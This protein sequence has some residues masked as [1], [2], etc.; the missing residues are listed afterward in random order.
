MTP[1]PQSTEISVTAMTGST[2]LPLGGSHNA[3]YG[4]KITPV[5]IT[6]DR[7]VI[8]EGI[9]KR[10]ISASDS[11]PRIKN[12]PLRAAA[13]VKGRQRLAKVAEHLNPGF[14]PLSALRLASGLSQAELAEKMNMKQPNI[15]RLE[16]SPGDP[17]LSTLRKLAGVLGVEVGQV[18]AA[19]EATNKA[20]ADRV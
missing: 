9:A 1:Q 4:L 19:V 17:S 12:N 13:I 15:A 7:H 6:M 18:I 20:E 5:F 3:I 10:G 14:R 8:A 16:K 11:S 2:F